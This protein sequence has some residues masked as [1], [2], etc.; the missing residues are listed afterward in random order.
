MSILRPKRR[1]F[2]MISTLLNKKISEEHPPYLL[3]RSE[4]IVLRALIEC[5]R[6]SGYCS[7]AAATL[8]KMTSYSRDSV[9]RALRS[10]I[11]K[12]YVQRKLRG[13][14]TPMYLVNIDKIM[15]GGIAD[16]Q[17]SLSSDL[18]RL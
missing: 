11:K 4:S 7:P 16:P 5:M 13:T 12:D 15:H 9:L 8:A 3:K 6:P 1:G 18:R 2:T 10:L 14:H 17:K